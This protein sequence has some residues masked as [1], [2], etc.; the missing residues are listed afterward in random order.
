MTKYKFMYFSISKG[1]GLLQ[2]HFKPRDSAFQSCQDFRRGV[3][4]TLSY[5]AYRI[6]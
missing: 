2:N 5:I 1:R 6:S 3:N 4:R